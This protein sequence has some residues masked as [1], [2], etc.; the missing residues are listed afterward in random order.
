MLTA[1]LTA[2]ALLVGAHQPKEHAPRAKQPAPPQT[3]QPAAESPKPE[4]AQTPDPA[5]PLLPYPH[6]LITEVLYN[7][8][9]GDAGDAN[10]D[11]TRQVVGDEFIEL[12]NPHDQP[13]NLGGY[14]LSDMTSLEKGNNGKP[15]PNSIHWTFPPLTLKPGQV[16]VVFNGNASSIAGPLGDSSIA[17]KPNDRFHDAFVFTMRQP[18]DRI[19]FSNTADWVMLSAPDGKPIHI[20]KWGE[21]RVKIPA[22][23]LLVEEAT[24]S[25]PG[26]FQRTAANGPLAPHPADAQGGAPFS[27]GLFTMP[28][29][30]PAPQ[31]ETTPKTPDKAAKPTVVPAIP[32][33]EPA[34]PTPPPPADNP[35]PHTTPAKKPKF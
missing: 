14:T 12:I 33:A 17:A 29:P 32:S 11:G 21:P 28:A 22:G 3:K 13:I 5:K 1:A 35:Q 26:S 31:P 20:I 9:S 34:A 2:T 7:V 25:K 27:P 18:S 24:G 16:A 15:K 10:K 30:A 23:V 4:P 8:P 19:G 6:P